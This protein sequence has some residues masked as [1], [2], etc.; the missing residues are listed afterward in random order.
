MSTVCLTVCLSAEWLEKEWTIDSC[1]IFLWGEHLTEA[2][3][4]V[5]WKHFFCNCVVNVW[6]VAKAGTADL[7]RWV[8][9]NSYEIP[10]VSWN[11]YVVC[12]K[13]V[14]HTCEGIG[15]YTWYCTSLWIITSEALRY[16]TCSQGISQFYLH[17]HTFIRNR[18][19]PYL[20]LPSQL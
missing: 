5:A 4:M 13:V 12:V 14:N 8:L 11:I 19:K 10:F 16:G 7:M 6:N 18:N 2:V 17:T 1:Y 3:I 9:L 15:T 20:P